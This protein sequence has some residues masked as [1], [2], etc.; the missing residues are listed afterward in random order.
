MRSPPKRKDKKKVLQDL[1]KLS[2]TIED[3]RKKKK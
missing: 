3:T 2:P 1:D